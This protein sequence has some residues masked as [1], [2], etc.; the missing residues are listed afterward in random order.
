MHGTARSRMVQMVFVVFLLIGS[1]LVSAGDASAITAASYFLNVPG[2]PGESTDEAHLGD[3]VVLNFSLDFADKRCGDLRVIKN[4]DRASPKLM[5]NAVLGTVFS[6]VILRGR[7]GG[8][9][10]QDFLF[11]QLFNAVVKTVNLSD[12]TGEPAAIEVVTIAAQRIDIAYRPQNPDGSLQD[13]V[14]ATMQC[15]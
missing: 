4:I 9:D 2:I 3:I 5:L 1:L 13:A 14:R 6:S 12:S 11:L 7:T 8:G 10:P 15:R